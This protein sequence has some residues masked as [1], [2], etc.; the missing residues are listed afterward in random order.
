[1]P[2]PDGSV[3]L[4]IPAG[5]QSG[6]KLRL[7][8]KGVEAK[9]KPRGDLIAQLEVRLP[10]AGVEAVEEALETVQEAFAEDPR[11]DLKL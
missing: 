3:Q 9:G 2:T 7:R 1:M 6:A 4:S 10:E 11:A 5:S 8:G